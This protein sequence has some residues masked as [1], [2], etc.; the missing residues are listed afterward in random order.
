MALPGSAGAE[1][2]QK[3]PRPAE[4]YDSGAG[5][6]QKN[7]RQEE[8]AGARFNKEGLKSRRAHG[9]RGKTIFR[10]VREGSACRSTGFTALL[11]L[12]F[13]FT[14]I[15]SWAKFYVN[16]FSPSFLSDRA[17]S[18]IGAQVL[19]APGLITPEGI[20]GQGEIIGL[21]DSGLD[22]G[23]L[24]DLHPDFQSQPGRLPKVLMLKSWAGR[25]I[26]DDPLGHGTHLAG[27]I[28]GTGLASEGKYAGIAPEASLYFQALLNPEGQISLPSNLEELFRPAYAAGVRV[29]VDGWGGGPN[30][31]GSTSRQV[32]SF[33]R[34]HPDFL[35]VFGAGNSG[36]VQGSLTS[37]ANSK[38]ALVVGA[39]QSAR[40]AL[41]PDAQDTSK[42]APFS[43]RGPTGDGRLKPDLLAPGT[44]IVA[45]RSRMAP[46]NFPANPNYNLESG[47]SQ[48]AAI[49][50]GAAALLRQYLRTEYGLKDPS[51]AL[52]KAT[53]IN[54]AREIPSSAEGGLSFGILDLA[55]TVLSLEEKLMTLVD[56][57]RGLAAGEVASYE[58]TVN[59]ARF[60]LK[61]TLAWTDPPAPTGASPT[62]V[63]DLDLIVVGPD[64]KEYR[65]NDFTGKGGKDSLNNVEQVY[66]KNPQPGRYLI[67]V[68]ASRVKEPAVTGS[69]SPRQDF[70]LSYGQ[71]VFR[72]IV[73]SVEDGGRVKTAGGEVISLPPGGVKNMVNGRLRSASAENILPGSDIY[74][75]PNIAYIVGAT[76]EARGVQVLTTSL[77]RMVVE[78]SREAR[79]GGFYLNPSFKVPVFLNGREAR[80]EDVPP[81]A[82][83]VASLNP[84]TLTLWQVSAGIV[85][86][87]GSVDK[88]DKGERKIWLFGE[89]KPYTIDP[90]AGVSFGDR[91][92]AVSRADLPWGAPDKGELEGILPGMAVRLSI[93]PSTG[94]VLYLEVKREVALGRLAGIDTVSGRLT[95]DTG[96]ALELF[97]VAPVFR[98]G[99][100]VGLE[101]LKIGDWV[102]ALVLPGEY[103][104]ISLKAYS[105][106]LYGRLVYINK[107]KSLLY[108][109]DNS[110]RFHVLNLNPEAEVYRWGLTAS[111]EALAAGDW[112]RVILAPGREEILRVD[113]ALPGEEKEAVLAGFDESREYLKLAEGTSYP[114]SPV[115]LVTLG[116]YRV[117]ARDLPPGLKARIV[118]IPTSQGPLLAQV[119]AE[120]PP[121]RT[122]PELKV[123]AFPR[124]D[125][126][127]ITGWTSADRLY[128]YREDGSY[129]AVNLLPGGNF[130]L[131][132][133]SGNDLLLVALDRRAGTVTGQRLEL[134]G[135]GSLPF[136]DI[137]GH[138]AA[139]DIKALS[140]QGL[141]AGYEDGSFRP[142]NPISR[143]EFIVFLDRLAE[144]ILPSALPFVDAGEI[145]SWAR[146]AV[147]RAYARGWLKGFEDG[148]IRPFATLTRV[149]AAA[150][151]VRFMGESA[152]APASS[153][154]FRDLGEVP[155]WA[156]DAV[157]RT[158]AA[159]LL[160]GLTPD[161]L[162]PCSPLT[163]AQAA[164]V[165]KRLLDIVP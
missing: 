96:T 23:K 3:G 43:S 75:G 51:A 39:S 139:Q 65:G 94:E 72:S 88:V 54:G 102:Q 83:V 156:K 4:I 11:V 8:V 89:D 159:G 122:D 81:G 25:N 99:R 133:E 61:V 79:E 35:V 6:S 130:Y 71:V 103:K 90:R 151:L 63:N 17:A 68:K 119:A 80:P 47:T 108:L 142:D 123:S 59:D 34:G 91:L 37:E 55:G 164:A 9:G 13:I 50:G 120:E 22:T 10:G 92:V 7:A 82:E 42:Q 160:R 150:F 40:P 124:G 117:P 36:P 64:G 115:T 121:G 30:K 97:P 66:I 78:I 29:H 118:Y 14:P 84:S 112:V 56:E 38:N 146:D 161:T 62:L 125:K 162:G 148:T 126:Y 93:S 12:L 76:W 128:V 69:S 74:L 144:V 104:V 109:V 116:G 41:S 18:I 137:Y 136:W 114:V 32:D 157:A 16:Y 57:A 100:Q 85:E 138:W 45:P 67:Q 105:R 46:S 31:Y 110:N 147:G 1:E 143:L 33:V 15:I 28:A 86:R 134:G 60:P 53:L 19:S 26:P 141:I 73:T 106:V 131:E 77:G 98:D 101:S 107:E 140:R 70:A 44:G 158:Y 153:L 21:A 113:I 2:G 149:E 52:L 145:P 20:K 87:E 152:H 95:L 49:A 135:E 154:P 129:Q 165:L 5:G 111:R 58:W 27:I 24:S 48:A 132:G 127:L 155:S 163:R